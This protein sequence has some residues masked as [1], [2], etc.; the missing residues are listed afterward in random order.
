MAFAKRRAAVFMNGCFW[1]GHDCPLFRLPRS[2]T[3][4]WRNKIEGNVTR[5]ARSLAALGERGWRTA[6]VW[7][8]AI[9]NRSTDDV[10]AMINGLEQWILGGAGDT[11]IRGPVAAA[12][13]DVRMA[14]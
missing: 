8:C 3:D 4:F 13:P 7:E 2:N 14:T 5:D 11:V 6:V 10:E 12:A 1:H 9:R